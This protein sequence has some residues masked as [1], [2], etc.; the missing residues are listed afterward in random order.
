MGFGRQGG[1]FW[2]DVL[3]NFDDEKV[4]YLFQLIQAELSRR[5]HVVD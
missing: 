2:P 5:F 3:Q 1:I 4:E